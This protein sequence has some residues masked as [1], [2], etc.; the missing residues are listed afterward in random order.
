MNISLMSKIPQ[1]EPNSM[2]GAICWPLIS[3]STPSWWNRTSFCWQEPAVPGLS[4]VA[5][6]V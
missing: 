5:A 3:S 6:G 2:Q 4:H 1:Q